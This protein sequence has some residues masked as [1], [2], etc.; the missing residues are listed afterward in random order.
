MKHTVKP[1]RATKSPPSVCSLDIEDILASAGDQST[2][3]LSETL[4][5]PSSF[6]PSDDVPPFPADRRPPMVS[7]LGLGTHLPLFPDGRWHL[8][9]FSTEEKYATAILAAPTPPRLRAMMKESLSI[10]AW[11]VSHNIIRSPKT[12]LPDSRTF[13]G[14]H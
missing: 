7:I 13:K 9:G 1:S 11:A 5:L 4:S 10:R 14:K 8:N 6:E 12:R 3:L 2:S